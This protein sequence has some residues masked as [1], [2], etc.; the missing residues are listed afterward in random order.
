MSLCKVSWAKLIMYTNIL[1]NLGTVTRFTWKHQNFLSL[2]C[3]KQLFPHPKHRKI[4]ALKS[5]QHQTTVSVS[6]NSLLKECLTNVEYSQRKHFLIK[7]KKRRFFLL[8]TPLGHRDYLKT[9]ETCNS[10]PATNFYFIKVIGYVM[11]LTWR[12]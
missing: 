12:M 9:G 7:K 3:F 6:V 5:F 8:K 2:H 1:L 11:Q 4:H 10:D